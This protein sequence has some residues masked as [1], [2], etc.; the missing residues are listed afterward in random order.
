M[1][2][3]QTL[4]ENASK[5]PQQIQQYV[6]RIMLQDQPGYILSKWGC[7]DVQAL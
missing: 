2:I 1:I 6:E 7:F 5:N 3:D 4:S